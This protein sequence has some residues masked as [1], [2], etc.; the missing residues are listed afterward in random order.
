MLLPVHL[1]M[2][3]LKEIFGSSPGII[4]W[5][6]ENSFNVAAYVSIYAV[7]CQI[8]VGYREHDPCSRYRLA[9]R[10]PCPLTADFGRT[11]TKISICHIQR[12]TRYRL[13]DS[14]S[15]G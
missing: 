8:I 12:T 6:E 9:R 5:H 11:A 3:I 1:R 10:L 7:N 14:Y 4:I 13:L 2:R 15:L